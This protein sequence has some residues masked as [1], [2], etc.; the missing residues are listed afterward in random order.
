MSYHYVYLI[1]HAIH[2]LIH[3]NNCYGSLDPQMRS[4]PNLIDAPS[5][6][7]GY[8]KLDDDEDEGAN[9]TGVGSRAA[10]MSVAGLPTAAALLLSLLAIMLN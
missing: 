8:F 9:G 6:V 7:I 10:G 3:C 2:I 5:P 1:I 4:N